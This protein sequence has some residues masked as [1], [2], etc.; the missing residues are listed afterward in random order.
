MQPLLR[1]FWPWQQAPARPHQF[2][3]EVM[4]LM[5]RAAMMMTTGMK[6]GGVGV[7]GEGWLQSGKGL[8]RGWDLVEH[9]WHCKRGHEGAQ[10]AGSPKALPTELRGWCQKYLRGDQGWAF[11]GSAAA[12]R[13][14][15]ARPPEVC[16]LPP[17]HTC[18]P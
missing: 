11:R 13:G 16:A 18:P 4:G 3:S 12:V 15:H 1:R 17:T 6:P 5:R 7:R 10:A 8:G 9:A 2:M 14:A